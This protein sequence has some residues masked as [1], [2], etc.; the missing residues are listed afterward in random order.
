MT[1]EPPLRDEI[2][3]GLVA[4]KFAQ[5]KDICNLS[6]KPTLG[7]FHLQSTVIVNESRLYQ[8]CV[9][10]DLRNYPPYTEVDNEDWESTITRY[11]ENRN[12]IMA[13]LAAGR[14]CACH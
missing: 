10:G 1:P 6:L 12:E 4:E 14:P 13:A 2:V 11:L 7:C 8:C 5:K 9:W 3:E